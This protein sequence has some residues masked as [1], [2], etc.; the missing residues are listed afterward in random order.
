M[1]EAKALR[2]RIEASYE[3][4]MTLLGEVITTLMKKETK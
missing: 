1:T 2:L 4:T 3:K